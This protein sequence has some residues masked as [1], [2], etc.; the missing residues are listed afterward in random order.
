MLEC[1]FTLP[2][3]LDVSML[4]R[5]GQGPERTKKGYPL[6]ASKWVPVHTRFVDRYSSRWLSAPLE[7]HAKFPQLIVFL[8]QIRNFLQRPAA[9]S[10]MPQGTIWGTTLTS[11]PFS[12][13]NPPKPKWND[14]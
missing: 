6:Q 14:I 5:V 8:L 9:F 4:N 12:R 10:T 7:L 11:E 2:T 3:D 13:D 1:E